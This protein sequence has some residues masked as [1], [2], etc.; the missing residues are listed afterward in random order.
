MG[1]NVRIS[2]QLIDPATEVQ[3]WSQIYKSD[4]SDIFRIKS[5]VAKSVA[6]KFKTIITPE[7]KRV[8]ERKPTTNMAAYE[9]Y[10]RRS[11]LPP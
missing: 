1:D 6:R 2:A 10:W 4:M 5:K 7:S 9:A 8:F 11:A 3:I